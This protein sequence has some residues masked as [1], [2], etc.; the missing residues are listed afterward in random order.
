MGLLGGRVAAEEQL[1]KLPNYLF[2]W[3]RL[4]NLYASGLY[5]V[6]SPR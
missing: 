2:E 1:S 4:F 3:A 5:L 6:D